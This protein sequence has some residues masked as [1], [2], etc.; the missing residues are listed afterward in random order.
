MS[1]FAAVEIK[2]GEREV[3]GIQTFFKYANAIGL[4]FDFLEP[5][6]PLSVGATTFVRFKTDCPRLEALLPFFQE[7]ARALILPSQAGYLLVSKTTEGAIPIVNVQAARLPG[8]NRR[9]R[10]TA[11]KF[12]TRQFPS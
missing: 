12:W 9:W 5:Y 8:Y 10:G 3:H 6:G 1:H 2:A 11:N 4:K 7:E